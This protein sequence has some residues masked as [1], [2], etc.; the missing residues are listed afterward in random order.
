[1]DET[2]SSNPRQYEKAGSG[3][4]KNLALYEGWKTMDYS[5]HINLQLTVPTASVSKGLVGGL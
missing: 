2:A 1:M 5:T 3:D 4:S